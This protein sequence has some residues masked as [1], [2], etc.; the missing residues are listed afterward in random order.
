M[1][2]NFHYFTFSRIF[3]RIGWLIRIMGGGGGGGVAHA[4]ILLSGRILVSI[5]FSPVDLVQ[6]SIRVGPQC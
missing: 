5:L 6:L 1:Y 4:P 3:F 2:I